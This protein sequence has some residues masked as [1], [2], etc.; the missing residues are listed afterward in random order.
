MLAGLQG[1]CSLGLMIC[2][3]VQ[4]MQQIFWVANAEQRFAG[5][6]VSAGGCGCC[7][8]RCTSRTDQ[9]LCSHQ[10]AGAPRNKGGAHGLL[11]LQQC[12]HRCALRPAEI[13]PPKGV[14][15]DCGALGP[16]AEGVGLEA[17]QDCFSQ[18]VMAIRYCAVMSLI[19]LSGRRLPRDSCVVP[20]LCG[21]SISKSGGK[22]GKQVIPSAHM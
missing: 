4:G 21:R 11:P 22:G 5:S 15:P 14:P 1:L 2:T 6:W 9:G 12:G 13:W 18:T 17:E 8:G 20:L 7:D 10:A 16:C 3:I 19:V